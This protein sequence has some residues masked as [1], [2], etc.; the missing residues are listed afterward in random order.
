MTE[1]IMKQNNNTKEIL[2]EN[3]NTESPLSVT[4]DFLL[5]LFIYMEYYI[6]INFHSRIIQ[7]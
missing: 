1:I 2:N 3:F 4:I 6:Y 5:C 7:L